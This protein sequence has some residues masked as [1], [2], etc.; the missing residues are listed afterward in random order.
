MS[1]PALF[2]RI[3]RTPDTFGFRFA[4]VCFVMLIGSPARGQ[5][6][7]EDRLAPQ[8]TVEVLVSNWG[9]LRDGASEALALSDSFTIGSDGLLNLPIIGHISAAGQSTSQLAE[10]INDRLQARSGLNERAVTLVERKQTALASDGVR[11]EGPPAVVQQSANTRTPTEPAVTTRRQTLEREQPTTEALQGDPS[12]AQVEVEVARGEQRLA[13]DRQLVTRLTHELSAARGVITNMTAQM[14]QRASE[15]SRARQAAEVLA[16]EQRKLAKSERAKG[17][18]LD[19]EL[20][21]A[22]REIDALKRDAQRIAAEREKALHDFT[23]VERELDAMRLVTRDG[24]AQARAGLETARAQAVQEASDAS[25]ARQAAEVLANEQRELAKSE[26]AKGQALEHDLL[27]ARRE[28]EALKRGATAAEREARRA[29]VAV[30]ADLAIARTQ[31]AQGASETSRARQAAEVL[32]NEQR[33]LAK[34]E[35]AKGAALEH[36][37]LAA[38]REVEALKRDAQRTAAEREEAQRN[39]VAVQRELDAMRLVVRNGSAQA[40]TIAKQELALEGQRQIA[41]GL[42]RELAAVQREFQDLKAKSTLASP[43]KAADVKTSLA[44]DASL[45]EAR[46]AID[47]ERQR[48]RMLESDLAAARQFLAVLEATGNKAAAA[49][50]I[51][52]RD[53]QAAE[54]ATKRLREAL[55][56]QRQRAD[57][58]TGEVKTAHLERDAAKQEA[59]RMVAAQREA[60]ADEQGK[61]ISL[62]RELAAARK[63]AEFP[64]VPWPAGHRTR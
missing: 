9:A 15:A 46:R 7:T 34:S 29:W 1:K 17:V 19:Q 61:A 24:S 25:R 13:G 20:L 56:L 44:V 52:I 42:A 58:A 31:A 26:R 21:A 14:A 8:D 54:A 45:A 48:A 49:Q 11:V 12:E 55:L 4:L 37:L 10:L 62:A 32:A 16:N 50:A 18:A 39:L 53:L 28:I 2:S 59:V 41:D 30:R 23:T 33:E 43:S 22:R 51:A 40:P 38:R 27:A 35:R 60:L 57:A 47:Q 5:S 63:E 6:E 36:D 64:Q 3:A